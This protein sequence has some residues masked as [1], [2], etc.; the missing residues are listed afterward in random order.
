MKKIVLLVLGLFFLGGPAL[1]YQVNIDTPDSLAVGKP[2]VVTG[3]TTFGI[4]TPIDV[5][6]YFQLTTTTEIKRQI[7]Y[8]N[9]DKT[10][11]T[12]FDTTGLQPGTYKIEVPANGNS[13]SV[14]MRLITLYD[15]SD[16]IRL[17]SSTTQPFSGKLSIAGTIKGDENSGI[18]VEVRDPDERVVFGPQYV[19]T[20]YL[21]YFSAEIP[22]TGPGT[23]AVSFTDSKGFIGTIPIESVGQ[24]TLS[25]TSPG[26]TPTK[27]IVSA[28]TKASRDNPAYFVVKTSSRPMTLYTSSSVD[29]VIEYFD[30]SGVLHVENDQGTAVPEKVSFQGT[31]KTMYVKVYPYKYSDNSEVFL[32][33]ENA[34]S[35]SVSPSVP[36]QFAASAP[37]TATTQA[38]PTV[39]A[40]G[41]AACGIALILWRQKP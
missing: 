16:E 28:H 9:S 13:D 40:I 4:G 35:V 21:G 33:A 38:S 25:V 2:L 7:V 30:D 23:Y 5:V 29:W 15:R 31:G 18:Q 19:N 41:L 8:V 36:A 27:T 17:D 34:L 37:Q 10:F 24:P 12:V 3:T 6:L 11:K 22:I 14:T 39:P 20:N 32:Y 26:A 1:G